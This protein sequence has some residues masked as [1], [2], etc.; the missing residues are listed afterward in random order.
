MGRDKTAHKAVF[1]GTLDYLGPRGHLGI[2]KRF[3]PS[4]MEGA[5]RKYLLLFLLLSWFLLLSICQDLLYNF[6]LHSLFLLPPV[7]TV[8]Q[9]MGYV[10][11]QTH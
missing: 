2:P 10:N 1:V 11:M 8:W 3:F 6:M 4:M 7:Q 9:P 5:S